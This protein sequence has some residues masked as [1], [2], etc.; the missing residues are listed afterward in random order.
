MWVKDLKRKI[1]LIDIWLNNLFYYL[2]IY[3]K[4]NAQN[5]KIFLPQRKCIFIIL[6]FTSFN[7][8]KSLT[9]IK[10]KSMHRAANTFQKHTYIIIKIENIFFKNYPNYF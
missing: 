3:W 8:E 1:Y 9:E 2:D 4:Q 6:F 7:R 10:K 5:E